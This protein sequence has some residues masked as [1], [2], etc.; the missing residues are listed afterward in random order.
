MGQKSVTGFLS[1]AIF[2]S[3]I[4]EFFAYT[5]LHAPTAI[6]IGAGVAGLASAIRLAAQGFTVTV[7]EKNSQAGGKI[8][9]FTG[10]G[11]CFDGGPSLFT[12]PQNIEELFALANEPIEE[13]FSYR[14]VP[15]ACKYFYE[16]G[17]VVNGYADADKL[18]TELSEK[19]GEKKEDVI[20]Y[21]ARSKKLYETTGSIFLNYSLHKSST[22]L[23]A[24]IGKALLHTSPHYLLSTFHQVNKNSFHHPHT[25]QLFNRY[26]T[27]NG[28]NPYKA[29][30]MLS[31]IP[32]LEYNE[33]VYYP[34]GG[35]ITIAEALY[36]LAIKKGVSF[37]FNT[38][39]QQIV[40]SGDTVSGVVVNGE[41]VAA[42][43]IVS[44]MDVYFTY[45][46]LLNDEAKAKNILKQERSSS[47]FIFY[48]GI[49][50]TFPQLEL[51]NIFFSNNYKEEFNHIFT[52]K[53]LYADPTVYINITSK[54]EPGVQAPQGKENWFVMVNAPAN[55]GQYTKQ[56]QAALKKNIIEKLNRILHTDI[57]PMIE[58]EAILDPVLIESNTS[59]Y[60]GSLYGTS[61][62]SK[63]AAFLRHPNFS[64]HLKH[65]Y[66]V[67]GSV[68][69]GGGI[70]LCLLSAKIMSGM[71]A[72]DKQNWQH[73]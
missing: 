64:R 62:N 5:M 26:A 9:F 30:G 46:H 61:S 17:T 12:Q 7:Y 69:P 13:Y 28:S 27:Y 41:P 3:V 54:C 14:G 59:S 60:M 40:R 45:K 38:P 42:D 53:Q 8:S 20:Q 51:H 15:I 68:H 23:Q 4:F 71:V 58:T 49:N 21:I 43:V 32:H 16:D 24:P 56:W 1:S 35:M 39:V 11:Y 25:V 44:N 52:L 63:T 73:V 48:W 67:G 55:S 37:H 34:K 2:L 72:E 6:I 10:K 65:L 29:P 57:E 33:G 22:L 47:A 31:V 70:P 19:L 50:Q 36:K 66:F 18:A